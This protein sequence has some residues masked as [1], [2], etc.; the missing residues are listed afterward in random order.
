MNEE[1]FTAKAQKEGTRRDNHERH[2]QT[3]T[4]ASTISSVREVCVGGP[5]ARCG[6]PLPFFALF[7]FAVIFSTGFFSIFLANLHAAIVK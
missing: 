7:A 4:C 3:R 6:F 1:F 5:Q 2:E